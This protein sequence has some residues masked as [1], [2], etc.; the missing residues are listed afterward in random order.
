MR[1][2]RSNSADSKHS[3]DG[4]TKAS[5]TTALIDRPLPSCPRPTPTD[6]YDDW[7]SFRG[8]RN[9]DVCP[10]CFDAVFADTPFA[11]HFSQTRRYER[12]TER[13]CDFNSPWMRLAWLLTIKQRLSGLEN[14]YALADVNDSERPCPGYR[15]LSTDRMNWYGIVD[16]RDGL[17]VPSFVICAADVKMLEI[18]FPSVKGY[19]TRLPPSS[20]Y[21]PTKYVCSLRTGSKR[22]PK[23]LDLL[24]E[25]DAESQS[26]GQRP[27]MAKFLRMA[28]ENAYKGECARDKALVRKPWHF[29]P[30][31]PEFTVCEECYEDAI[32]P[33]VAAKSSSLPRFVNKTIQLVPTED[34]EVGSSCCLYSP[35]MRRVWDVSCKEDDFKYLERKVLERKRNE[36]ML[37]KERREILKWLTGLEKGTRSWERARDE[38]KAV[39]RAWAEYE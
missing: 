29:M 25:I 34:P 11:S 26:T 3:F 12:P 2:S 32:W 20:T 22:F 4:R 35:R 27:N 10:S 13:F 31:L 28:R 1:R 24:V 36:M 21:T 7:Y 37:G 30:S 38:L 17:H 15:E 8:Y 6:R 19:F 18:L 16:Q 33:A 9:F 39:E 5:R 14:L 23:Y